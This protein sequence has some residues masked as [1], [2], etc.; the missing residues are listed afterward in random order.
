M[1]WRT[2]RS[3]PSAHLE[4]EHSRKG[5]SQCK[6][7]EP[8]H[9]L[10][11]HQRDQC[12]HSGMMIGNKS[13]RCSQ[14]WTQLLLAL[15]GNCKKF[16]F[17]AVRMESYWEVLNKEMTW[18]D[19]R[20]PLFW[21]ENKKRQGQSRETSEEAITIMQ[22]RNEDSEEVRNNH[23]WVPFEGRRA[24]FADRLDVGK[25]SQGWLQGFCLNNWKDV[26]AETCA[27]SKF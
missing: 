27:A 6:V 22:V 23:F 3:E 18:F 5:N 26:F 7:S 8:I 20:F 11:K 14:G 13:R 2:L 16:S 17:Y 4:E 19:L 9:M 1:I 10:R 21:V 25:R 12:G 24:S 15:T